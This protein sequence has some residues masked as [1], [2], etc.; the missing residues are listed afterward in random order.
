YAD[1]ALL[2]GDPSDGLPGV[3][4]IGEKTAAKLIGEF[5]SVSAL[6]EA[7]SAGTAGLTPAM[8][9][10]LADGV[11]YVDQAEAV[12]LVVRDIDLP[13]VLTALP[14]APADPAGL[15]LFA[16]QWGVE[17][18]VERLAVALA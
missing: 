6:F 4:G 8:T 17:S 5:G 3:R 1:F 16:D 2:R 12:V 10:K 18:A 11:G 9:K 13:P 7:V 14:A 15:A